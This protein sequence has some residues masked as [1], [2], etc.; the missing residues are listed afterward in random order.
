MKKLKLWLFVPLLITTLAV[1]GYATYELLTTQVHS[2]KELALAA[3][4]SIDLAAI[5]LGL[6]SADLAKRGASTKWI[7]LQVWFVIAI[8]IAMNFYHGWVVSGWA[9]GFVGAIFPILSAILYENLIGDLVHEVKVANGEVLPRKPGYVKSRKYGDKTKTEKIERGFV[10][11]TEDLALAKIE[12]MQDKKP[13]NSPVAQTTEDKVVRQ[14]Q[15]KALPVQTTE[16]N[17]PDNGQ[18]HKTESGQQ[19]T[20]SLVN[21]VFAAQMLRDLNETMTIRQIL[22]VLMEQGIEDYNELQDKVS[23]VKQKPVLMDTVRRT[24]KRILEDK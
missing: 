4:V 5:W 11:L 3:A 13:D 15:T 17:S 18:T 7:T 2:P 1:S 12:T 22:E 16:D 19:D 6:H 14:D 9:G 10:S 23:E 20:E 21:S 24:T 8:S